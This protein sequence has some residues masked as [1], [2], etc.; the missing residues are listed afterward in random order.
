MSTIDLIKTFATIGM[1]AAL[2]LSLVLWRSRRR[3]Q[4]PEDEATFG[5]FPLVPGG[6]ERAA[7]GENGA[8]EGPSLLA[9]ASET[10]LA[11]PDVA[12]TSRKEAPEP[13]AAVRIVLPSSLDLN[14]R[15]E[16]IPERIDGVKLGM[17]LEVS[18]QEFIV[19][20]GGGYTFNLR[21]TKGRW[22]WEGIEPTVSEDGRKAVFRLPEQL[23]RARVVKS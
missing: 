15:V 20:F 6:Q 7:L 21:N 12:G 19:D 8:P 10:A 5:D 17:T 1:V 23:P 2:F 13:V 14:L 22:R 9:L 16:N 4:A 11:T 3:A 18:L